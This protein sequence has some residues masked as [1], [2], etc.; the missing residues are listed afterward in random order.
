MM[1]FSKIIEKKFDAVLGRY[2]GDPA[3]RYPAVTDFPQLNRQEFDCSGDNGVTLKGAFYYEG[4]FRPE[5]LVVFDHGIGAGHL[6]YL[7]EIEML[8]K[9]GYTVYAYDHTG[10]VSTGGSGIL[11]FA[12]GVNDLDHVLIGLRK[13][14][15]FREMPV[16]LVGHS[17]GGYACMNAAALHPEVTHVVSLAG[18]L[19]AR[20]L[21]EQYIPK[22][23]LKHAEEVMDRE[24]RHN[25]AYADLDARESLR[26]SDAKLL[27]LQSRDDSKVEFERSCQLLSEAL[28]ERVDTKFVVLEHHDHDPQRTEQAA[29]ANRAMLADLNQKRK[30]KQ[31]TTPAQLEAFQASYDWELIAQQDP[32]IWS[33]IVS[34][35]EK[36]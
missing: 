36:N 26:K 15:R 19:S 33:K 27:H 22:P 3:M 1:L 29:A 18:F 34:F 31:L 35:L 12:Q 20:A 16:K 24:R 11:G 25:P 10:C 9:H 28:K 17:W 32:E 5:K 30:K 14:P 2:D 8:A 6:A 21:V 7:R 13:D 4:M 23:F